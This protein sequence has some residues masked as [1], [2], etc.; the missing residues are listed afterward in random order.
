MSRR[1]IAKY[2]GR[3]LLGSRT[4]NGVRPG[5]H[6]R[7]MFLRNRRESGGYN[8]LSE[9]FGDVTSRTGYLDD[10]LWEEAYTEVI[11]SQVDKAG[12]A[13]QT[14][15]LGDDY[16]GN[17]A[18]D[19]CRDNGKD[20]NPEEFISYVKNLLGDDYYNAINEII[21]ECSEELYEAWD[22]SYAGDNMG[23]KLFNSLSSVRLTNNRVFRSNASALSNYQAAASRNG[24]RSTNTAAGRAYNSE[25]NRQSLIK[26]FGSGPTKAWRSASGMDRSPGYGAYQQAAARNGKIIKP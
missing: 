10:N 23:E 22:D 2:I 24:Y 18:K 17:Y 20:Y 19:Y 3:Q 25:K 15:L 11:E 12:N 13:G 8:S 4:L 5:S 7:F 6:E 14:T 9:A 21:D 26:R 1:T 16:F